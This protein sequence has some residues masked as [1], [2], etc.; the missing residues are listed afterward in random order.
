[1]E[2][3]A[4]VA[5]FDIVVPKDQQIAVDIWSGL[6]IKNDG[7]VSS[8][9]QKKIEH[10]FDQVAR[11]VTIPYAGTPDKV[12]RAAAVVGITAAELEAC[13]RDDA[14]R[15]LASL[16]APSSRSPDDMAAEMRAMTARLELMAAELEKAKGREEGDPLNEIRHASG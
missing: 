10:G 14:A 13:G 12:A 7:T 9:V 6:L 11:G 2:G 15:V 8:T 3:N 4:K 16:P 1:M 5:T